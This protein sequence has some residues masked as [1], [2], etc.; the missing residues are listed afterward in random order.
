MSSDLFSIR[1]HTVPC[2]HIREY[3]RATAHEQESVL[4]L[5]VKQYR[6]WDNL[7]AEPGDVTIIGAHA[8]GFPKVYPNHGMIRSE[9]GIVL[10]RHLGAVRAPMG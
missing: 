9:S 1:E 8:N 6:P 3:P 2:Q 5:S 10:T 7:R 4:H